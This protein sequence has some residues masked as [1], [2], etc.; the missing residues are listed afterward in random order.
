[1]NSCI[2]PSLASFGQVRVGA[3]DGVDDGVGEVSS[4]PVE[5]IKMLAAPIKDSNSDSELTRIT[6]LTVLP[7]KLKQFE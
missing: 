6:A 7:R 4:V 2:Q 5:V 1:M 3:G